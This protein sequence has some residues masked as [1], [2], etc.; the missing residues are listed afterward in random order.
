MCVGVYLV[1]VLCVSCRADRECVC[2]VLCVACCVFVVCGPFG[3]ECKC[4]ASMI[5]ARVV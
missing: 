3:G 2:C 1:D 5:P 4:C